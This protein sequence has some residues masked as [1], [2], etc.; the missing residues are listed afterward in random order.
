VT[1]NPWASAVPT[2]SEYVPGAATSPYSTSITANTTQTSP[3]VVGIPGTQTTNRWTA[4]VGGF[5]SVLT[6]NSDYIILP[7]TISGTAYSLYYFYTL[8][9]ASGTVTLAGTWT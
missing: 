8:N 5:T 9:V 3:W 1:T 7:F 2:A 6:L 4:T